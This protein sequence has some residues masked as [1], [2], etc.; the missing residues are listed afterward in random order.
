MAHH[1]QTC[2]DDD[3][4]RDGI[5]RLRLERVLEQVLEPEL[6]SEPDQ[7]MGSELDQTAQQALQR[8][9]EAW[10]DVEFPLHSGPHGKARRIQV[11]RSANE[12]SDRRVALG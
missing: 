12:Q 7:Q 10:S 9:D 4:Y 5:L 1:L 6:V 2:D 8:N 11:R 3:R